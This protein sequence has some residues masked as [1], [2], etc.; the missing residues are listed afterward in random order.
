MRW[1]PDREL[2][3]DTYVKGSVGFEIRGEFHQI[4]QFFRL[5]GETK[6]V[7]TIENLHLGDGVMTGGRMVLTA[8]FHDYPDGWL[9]LFR[10]AGYSGDWY[11]TILE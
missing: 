11:W 4:L 1:Q 2:P 9:K 10:E 7:I 3:I 5:I 8:K 6:R